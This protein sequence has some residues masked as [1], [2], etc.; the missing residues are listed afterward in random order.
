MN[1]E[2]VMRCVRDPDFEPWSAVEVADMFEVVFG[3]RPDPRA[4][5]D[6]WDWWWHVCAEVDWEERYG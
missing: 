3:R 1:K 4:D 5:G 2:Q 6:P